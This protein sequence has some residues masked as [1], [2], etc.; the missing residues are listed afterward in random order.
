MQRH[1]NSG[2]IAGRGAGRELLSTAN[3]RDIASSLR[4]SP[5]EI[6]IVQGVFDDATE[7]AIG[8]Q[9]GI[10][11]HTVHSYLEHLYRK[12]DVS[13]RCGLL[14]RVFAECVARDAGNRSA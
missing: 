11:S 4:F 7:A 9:L 13:S 6:E 8:L 3:W 10:S 1:R 2:A 14:V 12:L 5:R